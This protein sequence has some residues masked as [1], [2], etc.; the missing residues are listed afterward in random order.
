MRALRRLSLL[1][2][3]VVALA[4]CRTYGGYGTE[5]VS[6]LQILEAN[7]QFADALIRAQ[8]E[9]R[10]LEVLAQAEP[11][12]VPY[13][14]RYAALV[15]LHE[16]V[17]GAHAALTEEV[18]ADDYRDVS[19][20]LGAIVSE[21]QRIAERYRGLVDDSS[22]LLVSDST[23]LVPGGVAPEG[24]YYAVPPYYVRLIDQ[25]NEPRLPAARP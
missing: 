23:A 8:A 4:G 7:E 10:A 17:L 12:L 9:L 14:L 20:L 18:D 24:R 19:R 1:V 11:A 21:H 2:L 15:N 13:A 3:A 6:Y 16:E 5:E 25:A 22:F